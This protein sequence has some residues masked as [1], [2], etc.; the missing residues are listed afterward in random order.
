MALSR[1]Y[2]LCSSWSV[3]WAFNNK[4]SHERIHKRVWWILVRDTGF[5]KWQ[6][7][8]QMIYF[9]FFHSIFKSNIIT[10]AF[11]YI[12]AHLLQIRFTLHCCWSFFSAF[13]PHGNFTTQQQQKKLQTSN[14]LLCYGSMVS[15]LAQ[16]GSRKTG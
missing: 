10:A 15:Q 14:L 8:A 5:D 4:I 12:L 6:T 9:F 16:N 7:R 13:Y 3:R 11:L 1:V 2:L